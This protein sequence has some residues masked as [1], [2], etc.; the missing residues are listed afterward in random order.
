MYITFFRFM[1][2]SIDPVDIPCGV[3]Q[4]FDFDAKK[5]AELLTFTIVVS[6]SAENGISAM[7]WLPEDC[8]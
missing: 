5:F 4:H 7:F 3:Q 8:V 6:V 2:G 1:V